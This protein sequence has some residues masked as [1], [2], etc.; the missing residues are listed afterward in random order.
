MAQVL[1]GPLYRPE[2][3]IDPARLRSEELVNQVW[4]QRRSGR[5]RMCNLYAC[6]Q[7]CA[8]LCPALGEDVGC[9]SAG[10]ARAVA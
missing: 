7:C 5:R 10:H 3:A 1:A 6:A 2:L 8:S 9:G 4:G